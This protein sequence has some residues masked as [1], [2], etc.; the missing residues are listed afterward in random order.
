MAKTMKVMEVTIKETTYVVI[1]D[2]TARHNPYKVY[3][4]WYGETRSGYGCSYHRTK[5]VEYA[6]LESVFYFMEYCCKTP[7]GLI[8]FTNGVAEMH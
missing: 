5:V 1:K 2:N 3:R 8:T 4:K 6:N 7:S